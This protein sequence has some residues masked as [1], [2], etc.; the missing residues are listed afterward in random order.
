MKTCK[1]KDL[2]QNT[3]LGEDRRSRKRRNINFEQL[4]DTLASNNS[5]NKSGGIENGS[6]RKRRFSSLC[7]YVVNHAY[8][9]HYYMYNIYLFIYIYALYIYVHVNI[10]THLYI[11]V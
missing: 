8:K 5:N 10:C 11:C 9:K 6:F 2:G 1:F 7:K 3:E 4:D